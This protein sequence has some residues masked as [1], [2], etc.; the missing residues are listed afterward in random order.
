[1]FGTCSPRRLRWKGSLGAL[2]IQG[3]RTRATKKIP[4]TNRTRLTHKTGRRTKTNV[5][6]SGLKAERTPACFGT[7]S[8]RVLNV[9]DCRGQDWGSKV[10]SVSLDALRKQFQLGVFQNHTSLVIF[11]SHFAYVLSIRGKNV[12]ARDEDCQEYPS[13][14]ET[15]ISL[16]GP[17]N[18]S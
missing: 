4:F 18:G 3:C 17:C 1:M 5:I 16:E 15:D 8:L 13:F 10:E 9:C 14:R 7:V 2:K 12:E 11:Q 6:A